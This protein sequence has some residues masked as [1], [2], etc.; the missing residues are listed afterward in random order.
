MKKVYCRNGPIL[1]EF[2]IGE[3]CWH[4]ENIISIDCM[5]EKKC[6]RKPTSINENLDC[7]CFQQYNGGP[8]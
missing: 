5:G 1:C 4:P 7:N 2:L 8:F 6:Q 3:S